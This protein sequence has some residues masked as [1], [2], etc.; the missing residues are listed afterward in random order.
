MWKY[1][2]NFRHCHENDDV[3]LRTLGNELFLKT[4]QRQGCGPVLEGLLRP[5]DPRLPGQGLPGQLFDAGP[6]GAASDLY[7]PAGLDVSALCGVSGTCG[8]NLFA[9]APSP[10]PSAGCGPLE[11]KQVASL[12]SP[13]VDGAGMSDTCP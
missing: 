8:Q 1:G 5:W 4:V 11:T 12:T 10:Q 13:Y 9:S 2:H 3:I 7:P 6:P